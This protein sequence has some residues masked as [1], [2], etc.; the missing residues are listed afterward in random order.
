MYY[1]TSKSFIWKAIMT[2]HSK[3]ELMFSGCFL[4]INVFLIS[5]E[6]FKIIKYKCNIENK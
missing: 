5:Y 3:M 1:M 6:S 4:K 2:E